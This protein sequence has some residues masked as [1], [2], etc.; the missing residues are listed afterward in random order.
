MQKQ[1]TWQ[2]QK[3]K[4][5]YRQVASSNA[6]EAG[7]SG[8]KNSQGQEV[9]ESQTAQKGTSN[10]FSVLNSIDDNNIEK[11]EGEAATQEGGMGT[12]NMVNTEF[13]SPTT[14]GILEDSL[15]DN[16]ENLKDKMEDCQEELDGN[17]ESLI[18]NE[19]VVNNEV[20]VP[21]FTQVVDVSSTNPRRAQNTGRN[22]EI[23]EEFIRSEIHNLEK[24]VLLNHSEVIPLA[25]EAPPADSTQLQYKPLLITNGDQS[26][27]EQSET[28]EDSCE[29]GNNQLAAL[30]EHNSD[31]ELLSK[32]KRQMTMSTMRTRSQTNPHGS[33]KKP[34]CQC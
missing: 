15:E 23:A 8:A 3:S 9:I 2:T 32:K 18:T 7:P 34:G 19:P 5:V 6:L 25:I 20:E 16:Q 1:G 27:E 33:T 12:D 30:E 10:T 4:K 28:E 29:E 11:E 14:V 31:S 13:P 26:D 17:L 22:N 24:E 21:D